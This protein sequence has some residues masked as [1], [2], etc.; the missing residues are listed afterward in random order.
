MN[1]CIVGDTQDLCTVYVA[2]LARRRG[3]KVIE[4][5]EETLGVEWTFAFYDER[6]GEGHI[7]KDGK[8]YRIS[9]FCGAY[10]RLNPQPSVPSELNLPAE[11]RGALIVERRGGIQY[12]LNSMPFTIANR[13]CSGRSNSS[14]PFQMRLLANTGFNVPEWIVSNEESEVKE[15]AQT[16]L[17]GVIYKSCSGLRSHVQLLNDDVLNRLGKGTSPLIIQEYIKGRE[18]RVHVI[19]RHAFA[20]EVISDGID[21]RFESQK[22]EFQTTSVPSAIKKMCHDFAAAEGLTIAGFDFRIGED[23]TWYCLE[24]NPVPTFLP[25]EMSTGQPIGDTLLDVFLEEEVT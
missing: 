22:N 24:M 11:E 13:P 20:T 2:W 23:G 4:L 25:Y 18:V 3:L 7:Q 16:C 19:K 10:V 17:S 6:T 14:K 8:S 9:T 5:S 15:F 12:F 21:Y 1:I